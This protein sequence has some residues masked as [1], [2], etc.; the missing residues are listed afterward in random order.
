MGFDDYVAF[1]PCGERLPELR[2]VVDVMNGDCL[3]YEI[4]LRLRAEEVP[5][6][7]LSAPAASLGWSSWLG[8]AGRDG[9]A[10]PL[11]GE[12]MVPWSRLT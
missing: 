11:F 12:R 8:P 7:Q 6:L 4:E 9:D 2:E 3:D 5:P 10:R 1:S